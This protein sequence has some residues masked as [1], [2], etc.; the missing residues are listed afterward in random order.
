MPNDDRVNRHDLETLLTFLLLGWLAGG[1][2]GRGWSSRLLR[3]CAFVLANLRAAI[4]LDLPRGQPASDAVSPDAELQR[5]PTSSA[6][7]C[8]SSHC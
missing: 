8:H 3:A 2:R 7:G 1:S 4:S 6:V 5:L